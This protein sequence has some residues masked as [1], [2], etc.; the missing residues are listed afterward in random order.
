MKAICGE[1]SGKQDLIVNG[2]S[3]NSKNNFLKKGEN[4]EI[5]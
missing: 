5:N 3:G 2:L 1:M 4:Y